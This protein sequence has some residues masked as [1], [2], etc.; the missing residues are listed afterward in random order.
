MASDSNSSKTAAT[1]PKPSPR[2]PSQQLPQI[3]P[4][5]LNG[6]QEIGTRQQLLI[7]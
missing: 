4:P 2:I 7:V 5:L 3:L 1:P 6:G